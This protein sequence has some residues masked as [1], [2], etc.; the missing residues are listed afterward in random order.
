MIPGICPRARHGHLLN[1]S[2]QNYPLA[3]SVSLVSKIGM[4]ASGKYWSMGEDYILPAVFIADSF[5]LHLFFRL[6]TARSRTAD[7][8]FL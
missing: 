3:S 1:E 2:A 5:R 7:M 4:E 8:F 6:S